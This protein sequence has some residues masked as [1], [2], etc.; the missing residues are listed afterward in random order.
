MCI[1]TVKSKKKKKI[2][3][4]FGLGASLRTQKESNLQRV[5]KIKKGR[6]QLETLIMTLQIR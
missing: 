6:I 2:N 5:L 1:L 3:P 4:N